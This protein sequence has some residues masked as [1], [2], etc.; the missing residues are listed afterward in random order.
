MNHVL[1]AILAFLID[2]IFGEFGFVKHPIAFIKDVITF[3]ENRFYKD[4]IFRGFLLV[5]FVLGA[6]G[7][8]AVLIYI[9]L[10]MLN[11]YVVVVITSIVASIFIAHNILYDLIKSISTCQDKTEAIKMLVDYDVKNAD[12]NNLHDIAMQTYAKNLNNNL[13]APLFYLL[14]FNLPGIIIYKTINIMDS[15]VGYKNEKYEKFGKIAAKLDDVF[16][17]IPA[18][19]TAV[20]IMIASKQKNIFTFYKNGKKHNSP[21]TGHPISAMTIA[22]GAKP[23]IDKYDLSRALSFGKRVDKLVLATLV[24]IYIVIFLQKWYQILPKI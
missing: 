20:F 4:S 22:C 16:N 12:K 5:V 17:Y 15:M 10:N 11:K 14:L 18:R 23:N 24:L 13:I 1:V 2:K 3:F 7:G 6:V 19:F 9:Y 8:S 21:N